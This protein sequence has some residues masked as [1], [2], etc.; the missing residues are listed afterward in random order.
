MTSELADSKKLL[1]SHLTLRSEMRNARFKGHSQLTHM[2][3]RD[4]IIANLHITETLYY[5]HQI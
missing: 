2:H 5:F 4:H 1:R 3:I